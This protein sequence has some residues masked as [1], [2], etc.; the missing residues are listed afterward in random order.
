M[1]LEKEVVEQGLTERGLESTLADNLSFDTEEQMNATLDGLKPR[2][3]ET[4]ED[5]LKDDK[6]S[7]IVRTYGDKRQSDLQ[8]KIDKEKPDKKKPVKDVVTQQEEPEWAKKIRE[9]QEKLL[10]KSESDDF[11]KLVDKLGKSEKLESDDIDLVRKGL[12][13]DATEADIKK[14]FTDHKAYLGKKG[15]KEFSTPGGGSKQ[16]SS[17]GGKL[18]KKWAEKHKQKIKK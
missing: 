14:A 10:Q 9:Q 1:A 4:I 12:K 18:A 16:N 3:F 8:S 6:L 2:T 7:T 5:V 13:T 15:I 17:D 11:N